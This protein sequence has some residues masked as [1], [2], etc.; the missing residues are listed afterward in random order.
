MIFRT[1]ILWLQA[2]IFTLTIGVGCGPAPVP[3]SEPASPPPSPAPTSSAAPEKRALPTTVAEA[4]EQKK[5]GIRYTNEEVRPHYLDLVAGVDAANEQW[6]KEGLSAEERARRAYKIR[7]DARVT[8]RAMMS[9]P[10]EVEDLR[11]RDQE[12]YGN[13][14]GPT[15]EWLVTQNQKKGL[16]GDAAYEAIVGSSQRTNKKVNESF[17][18]K[19][20]E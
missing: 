4:E 14:D 13:P 9:D 6:L 8:T 12:K 15:F 17:D 1:A 19:G 5:A 18:L 11:K 3:A 7:H 16:T 10:S 20:K 2:L